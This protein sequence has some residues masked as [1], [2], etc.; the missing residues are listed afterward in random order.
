MAKFVPKDRSGKPIKNYRKRHEFIIP[1]CPSGV[2]VPGPSTGDV[3]KALKIFKRQMKDHGTLEELRDRQHFVKPSK[4]KTI[5][6]EAAVRAQ[7]K[8]DKWRKFND[9][10]YIWTAIMDGKAR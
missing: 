4:A 10:N 6:M 3:E 8:N 1:G 9:K 5:K 7:K 2:K